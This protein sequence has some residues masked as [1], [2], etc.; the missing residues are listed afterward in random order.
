[1][2]R[3]QTKISPSH[4][5]QSHTFQGAGER[6]QWLR[7]YPHP[8]PSTHRLRYEWVGPMQLDVWAEPI[9]PDR[10]ETVL[11]VEPVAGELTA[12]QRRGVDSGTTGPAPAEQAELEA[13]SMEELV[14][15]ATEAGIKV[16]RKSSKAQIAALILAKQK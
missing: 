2:I 1:M 3:V 16:P 4:S 15:R 9:E 5:R 12:E 8:M 11:K 14:T 7:V 13:L 6:D 10:K